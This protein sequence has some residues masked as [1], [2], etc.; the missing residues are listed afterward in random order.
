MVWDLHGYLCP[1][2][3]IGYRMEQTAMNEPGISH[4]GDNGAF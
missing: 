4:I 2:M 1:F 3:L